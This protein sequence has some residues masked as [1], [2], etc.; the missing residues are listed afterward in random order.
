MKGGGW[1]G[2]GESDAINRGLLEFLQNN[3]KNGVVIDGVV[4]WIDV[5]TDGVAEA[6][7][8]SQAEAKYS[9]EE[10]N[11]AKKALWDAAGKNIGDSFPKR[12]GKSKRGSDIDDI[13]KALMKL[14]C[15]NALPLIL[16]S[17]RMVARGPVSHGIPVD[18]SND[19]VVSRVS[20]LEDSMT[21]FMKQQ[22]EQIKNL[23]NVVGSLGQSGSKPSTLHLRRQTL[24]VADLTENVDS[25]FKRKRVAEDEELGV[26]PT[27]S[28][29]VPSNAAGMQD[30]PHQPPV[31][32]ERVI[33]PSGAHQSCSGL[34]RLVEM[35]MKTCWLL[36][37][38]W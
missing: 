2:G 16:A 23:T 38:A 17:S 36:M 18:A 5:Q 1:E 10:V 3:G 11:D 37:Y 7:W 9:D 25:P 29:E 14:K 21:A 27:V 31:I 19:D 34:Q 8:M 30:K 26:H 28:N 32:L 33:Q 15:S 20:S 4:A 13:H 24:R 35:T 6:I 12:I 22:N